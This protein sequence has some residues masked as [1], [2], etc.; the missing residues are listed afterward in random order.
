MLLGGGIAGIMR[1]GDWHVAG[2]TTR[3]KLFA[4]FIEDSR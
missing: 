1:R 3:A 2:S 4:A